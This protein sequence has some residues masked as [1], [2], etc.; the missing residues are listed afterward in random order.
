MASEFQIYL[1]G[2]IGLHLSHFLTTTGLLISRSGGTTNSSIDA[3][4]VNGPDISIEWVNE[5][6]GE[7]LL[8]M[9][10]DQTRKLVFNRAYELVVTTVAS[11][12][13]EK[14]H[15]IARAIKKCL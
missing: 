1:S 13:T 9:P 5:A 7:A 11:G 10:K 12:N 6:Q 8:S 14:C 15:A 4:L 2:Q 3:V